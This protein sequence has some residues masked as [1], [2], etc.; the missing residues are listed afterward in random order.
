[1]MIDG[2]QVGENSTLLPTRPSDAQGERTPPQICDNI[3]GIWT[4]GVAL[5]YLYNHYKLESFHYFDIVYNV[6]YIAIDVSFYNLL[7]VLSLAY[8]F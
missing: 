8:F 2:E 6:D 5:E 4:P 7:R 3:Q 1:M